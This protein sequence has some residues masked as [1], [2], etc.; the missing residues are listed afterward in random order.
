M[1]RTRALWPRLAALPAG[2]LLALAFPEADL[3]WLAWVALIPLLVLVL[4]ATT[5]REATI[6]GG[7]VARPSSW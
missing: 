1:T 4:D 7:S 3:W 2:A 6:R 5:G